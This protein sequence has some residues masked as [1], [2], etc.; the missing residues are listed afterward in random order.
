VTIPKT[1]AKLD[2]LIASLDRSIPT[3]VLPPVSTGKHVAA[4]IGTTEGALA[5]DRYQHKGIPY[6]RIGKRVRYLRADVIA[7]LA[8]NRVA[9]DAA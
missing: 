6:T 9:G 5:Q 3:D 4:V 7:F 2:G 8:S 1:S